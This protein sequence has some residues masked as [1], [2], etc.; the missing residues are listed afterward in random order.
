MAVKL[1]VTKTELIVANSF[2]VLY[3]SLKPHV[4]VRQIKRDFLSIL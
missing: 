2:A 1:S 3:C 4:V